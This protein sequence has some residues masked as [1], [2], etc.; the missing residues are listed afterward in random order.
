MNKT[1]FWLYLVTIIV[2]SL[3]PT[4]HLP[5]GLSSIWD[6][7]QHALGYA[8][9][10][11]LGMRAYPE[12]TALKIGVTLLVF[13]ALVEVAQA[14]TG[15]RFGEWSDLLANGVGIGFALV[16]GRWMRRRTPVP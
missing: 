11:A 7:A 16:A 4:A 12:W 2:L 14:A 6:K 9:L 10:A 8:L 5:D 15:W 1:V 3:S 13:G